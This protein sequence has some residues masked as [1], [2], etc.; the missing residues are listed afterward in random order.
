MYMSCGCTRS[1]LDESTV[2]FSPE[3][4]KKRLQSG[5][6]KR[7]ECRYAKQ[8]G[9]GGC[10]SCWLIVIIRLR[11]EERLALRLNPPPSPS[12][13]Q[14]D[15]SH[16]LW[17][18]AGCDWRR[19][20]GTAKWNCLTESKRFCVSLLASQGA[21]RVM[22]SEGGNK[23]A[24]ALWLKIKARNKGPAKRRQNAFNLCGK[25]E[26]KRK[27]KRFDNCKCLD[28]T[29]GTPPYALLNDWNNTMSR[30]AM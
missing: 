18:T 16:Q 5:G 12:E 27:G 8:G 28:S 13:G 21:G 7:D 1:N 9:G 26:M 6:N 2:N 29:A 4:F 24:V 25:G 22:Q 19:K 3:R 11:H 10:R 23:V 15:V 20:K 14:S 17:R 30:S